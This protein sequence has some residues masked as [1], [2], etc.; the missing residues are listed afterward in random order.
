MRIELPM[1]EHEPLAPYTA[2]R[3]GGPARWFV[4]ATT[5]AM[6][7]QAYSWAS[8]QHLPVF[9]LGG[10]SNMLMSD[11]GWPG[12]V[13][14]YRATT[15][16]LA[17]TQ[18]TTLLHIDAGAPMA[19]TARKLAAQG[20]AGL[21]WAEGLPGT[22][23]GAIYGNAGCYGGD[24]A[25][26]LHSATLLLPDGTVADWSCEQFDFGYRTS[27]LKQ[28]HSAGKPWPIVLTATLSLQQD[29]PQT[30]AHT[31]ARIAAARKQKTP[32]GSSCGSVFKNP[33][34]TS[35]GQV[36]D[37]AGLK[38]RRVG[39]AQVAEQHA[40]YIL[41]TGNATA[42]DVLALANTMRTEVLHQFGI[43]LELEV[44]VIEPPTMIHA[45]VLYE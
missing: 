18:T 5:P 9:M 29:D 11:V 27:R 41:N 19:G 13:I 32:A 25:Q 2:W 42:A 17:Q 44:R 3:I 22:V 28:F 43:E 37:Q 33:P 12:L 8:E 24:M 20:W 21:E 10:G 6:L 31:I 34:G 15:F 14:R 16:Q 45:K 39:G 36:L 1:R 23:G 38:G 26:V 30:I 40:N 35:A 4:Q 7:Q